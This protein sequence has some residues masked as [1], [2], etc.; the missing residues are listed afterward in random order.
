MNGNE[1]LEEKSKAILIKYV[2]A[3]TATGAVPVPAVSAAIVAE[4][5]L[6]I[7][8]IAAIY[9]CEISVGTV[10]ASIGMLGTANMIGREVFVEAAR[11]LSWGAAFVGAPAVVSAIGASTAG[12]QTYLI[13]LISIEIAKGGGEKLSRGVV[14]SLLRKGKDDFDDFSGCAA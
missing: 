10:I 1:N 2:L 7:N 11:L 5:S 6:M 4:N 13:G 3:A 12:L 9:G 14:K 8:H